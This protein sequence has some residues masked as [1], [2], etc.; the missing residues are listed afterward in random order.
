MA[1]TE[2]DQILEGIA[3][4]TAAPADTVP[5]TV[6][7][8]VSGDAG[9]DTV[10]AEG[11]DTVAG[12]A[13][14]DTVAANATTDSV[15][16][17][18]AAGPSAY[19]IA[20]D[21]LAGLQKQQTDLDAEFEKIEKDIADGTIM[22]YDATPKIQLLTARQSRLD[23]KTVAATAEITKQD[24]QR[25][26]TL[27]AHWDQL[28]VKYKD[29]AET[30]AKATTLLKT[31]WDEDFA[32]ESKAFPNAHPQWIVGRAE[33]RWENRIAALRAKKGQPATPSSKANPPGRLTPGTTAATSPRKESG[34]AVAERTLGPLHSYKF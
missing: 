12:D 15:V 22:D 29:I 26:E 16:Q 31:M 28:G 30:P 7:D 18:T 8:T 21:A 9:Q 32:K 23:K 25:A 2:T 1:E 3:P 4:D 34:A 27:N 5:A 24:S 11:D 20:V 17:P 14:T 33:V 10:A 6:D 19:Q 13:A